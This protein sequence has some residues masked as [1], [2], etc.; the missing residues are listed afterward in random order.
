ML[1]FI[2]I[3]KVLRG[4]NNILFTT[5]A[6]IL[7]VIAFSCISM[8]YE[9]KALKQLVY[10]LAGSKVAALAKEKLF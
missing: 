6:I 4:Y 9:P 8:R 5:Y 2:W 1:F 7:D 10:V 3:K